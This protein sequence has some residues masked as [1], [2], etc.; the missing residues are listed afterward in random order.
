MHH[1]DGL[2]GDL[3]GGSLELIEARERNVGDGVTLPLGGLMLQDAAANSIKKAE[4]LVRQ[5]CAGVG[6]L[7]AMKGRS[8]YAVGGTWRSLARLHMAA[9]DYPLRVTQGYTIDCA[10]ALALARS[11]H[12][13]TAADLNAAGGVASARRPLL[14]YGALVLERLLTDGRPKQVVFSAQGVREGLLYRLLGPR[15]QARD[16]LIAAARDFGSLRARSPRHGDELTVWSDSVF[17]AAVPD[18][19]DDERRL[20]HAACHLADISWRAHPDYR[21]Q[22]SITIIANAAFSGIDHPG[23]AYL[24]LAVYFRHEGLSENNAIWPRFRELATPRL[25]ERARLLGAL[26]RIA[27]L[28]SASMPGVLPRTPLAIEPGRVTLRLPQ[29]LADLGGERVLNRLK[30]FAKLIGRDAAI[31]IGA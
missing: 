21:G 3:G 25:I 20:R 8:F 24:A 30:Q 4:R 12:H 29:D 27:Y 5:A 2:I 1:A 18:E 23:R 13:M 15:E 28:V 16:P 10:E 6:Q 14:A 22:Q 11:V 19:T 31:G 26:M 9:H 17:A 7:K